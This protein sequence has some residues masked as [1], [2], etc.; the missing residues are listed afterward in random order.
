MKETTDQKSPIQPL[1]KVSLSIKIGTQP[2]KNDLNPKSPT[3]EFI[4]G[5]GV[6]G[7]TPFEFFLSKQF[8]G[9]SFSLT[10]HPNDVCHTFQHTTLPHFDI[11][12]SAESVFFT[13][14]VINVEK[15]DS[16][17]LIKAMAE[18]SSCGGSCDCCG[19]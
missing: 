4:F 10:L 2:G 17:E 19:H 9:N 3:F 12:E 1:N 11:P 14:Q 13:F 15:A 5:L 16:R 18:L 6:E 8:K 7:L